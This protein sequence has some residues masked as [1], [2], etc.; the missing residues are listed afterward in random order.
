MSEAL[1][2]RPDL[3]WY[4]KA[5]KALLREQ[6]SS[7]SAAKLSDAQLAIA[8]ESGFASWRSLVEQVTLLRASV[9]EPASNFFAH[10]TAAQRYAIG[11]PYFH[12]LAIDAIRRITKLPPNCRALDVGCGTGQSSI[13]LL[14]LADEIIATDAS[15]E[16]LACAIKHPRIQYLLSSA[17]KLPRSLETFDLITVALAFHW[18]DR[19]AFMPRAKDLVRAGGWLVI[20]NDYFSGRMRDNDAY[21]EWNRSEY[22]RRYPTPPR[23]YTP[24]SDAQAAEFGFAVLIVEQFDH[25]VIFTPHQLVNYLLTQ[26]NTIAAI[27]RGKENAQEVGQWLL[28]SV[29]ALFEG[30]QETVFPFRCEVHA[31]Q[32]I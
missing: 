3:E 19:A 4:R 10:D 12:P 26:T 8:R 18:L 20:Y 24:M 29:T 14:D 11:R 25:D 7:D 16:M 1:P 15:A 5:A 30:Q 9:P 28:S 23:N 13:A 2:A 6:R 27:E 31:Y 17:E 32:R 21:A 22:V